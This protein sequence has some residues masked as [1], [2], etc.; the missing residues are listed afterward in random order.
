[1]NIKIDLILYKSAQKIII[2]FSSMTRDVLLF[3]QQTPAINRNMVG[4]VP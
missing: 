1:M 2:Q 4:S 3:M